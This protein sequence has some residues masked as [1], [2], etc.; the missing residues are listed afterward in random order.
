MLACLTIDP[1]PWYTS[2]MINTTSKNILA[3]VLATENIIVRHDS[4][5]TTASFD[6]NKRILVLPTW[7]KMSTNLYDMCIG[8]EVG[9]ALY[10][11]QMN[12]TEFIQT[13]NR[14][15]SDQ[16]L[17]KMVWNIVEDARIE[18][19]I[20]ET[21]PGLRRDFFIGYGE[22][23]EM[24]IF[25]IDGVDINN[26]PFI[27][28]ANIFFKVGPVLHEEVQFNEM[29]KVYVDRIAQCVT[30]EEVILLSKEIYD[31]ISTPKTN[32]EK[33]EN[34]ESFELN[35][36]EN[37]EES[38]DIS[39]NYSTNWEMS[40]QSSNQSSAQAGQNDNNPRSEE[41]GKTFTNFE[42][43]MKKNFTGDGSTV[44][45]TI[46]KANLDKIVIDHKVLYGKINN[47]RIRSCAGSEYHYNDFMNRLNNHCSTI[48]ENTSRSVSIMVNQFNRK[49][50]ADE[51][52]RA[53]VSKTGK[54]NMDAL[55]KYR[56]SDDIFNSRITIKE[57]KNHGFV[58]LVDWSGSM[59]HI[60]YDTLV[61]MYQIA[62]FCRKIN[63][64][65]EVYAFSNIMFHH[66]HSSGDTT[67]QF[68]YDETSIKFDQM[69][70]L[71]IMSSRMTNAEMDHA[72]K[73]LTWIG[74]SSNYAICQ[75]HKFGQLISTPE[76]LSLN[77]TPLQA[78]IVSAMS[79]LPKFKEQTKSQI[80]N[81][82]ILTDGDSDSCYLPENTDCGSDCFNAKVVLHDK[83]T[84][85][86]FAVKNRYSGI[87]STLAE[88]LKN[89]T[90]ANI[91]RFHLD[92]IRKFDSLG[93][94]FFDGTET[95][96]EVQKMNDS[97][98]K[99]GFVAPKNKQGHDE[100]FVVKANSS[101]SFDEE[102]E[103]RI[104]ESK[105]NSFVALKNAFVK[106]NEKKITS[107]ILL[108]RFIDI[109]ST[110]N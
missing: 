70:M 77:C 100:L 57:G 71:N 21:Y 17:A 86:S 29:E 82:V 79:I 91:I 63:V 60:L 49:K 88:I 40:E 72:F 16:D 78:S 97:Y 33:E 35:V 12:V 90:G 45:A 68:E 47:S 75:K 50:A 32:P 83:M 30:H 104:L 84:G 13:I 85:A 80:V 51:S 19:M 10:T 108:N 28:R 14:I 65:F 107:K 41:H 36:P 42:K 81:C 5:A 1:N 98:S 23:L 101:V 20:K 96:E 11:P 61:Q 102:E 25:E 26:L 44:V 67:N 73:V 6:L 54:I 22:V 95:K 8:H 27:D 43:N 18:R 94:A 64:P 92:T 53:K 59:S 3:K 99:E 58:I 2:I 76:E 15:G 89:R 106:M 9:H 37:Q 7:D 105:K 110:E 66:F 46:P 52:R 62:F 87:T 56:L 74:L 38:E 34:T 31:M 24:D 109:I 39:D 4:K 48:R 55:Y 93:Y 103:N 69:N